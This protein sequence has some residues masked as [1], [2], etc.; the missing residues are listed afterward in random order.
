M[1]LDI[2]AVPYR[3]RIPLSSNTESRHIHVGKYGA[4]EVYVFDPYGMALGKLDRG[5]VSDLEDS[6]FMVK[7]NLL[8]LSEF[9]KLVQEAIPRALEFDMNPKQMQKHLA[10]VRQMLER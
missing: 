9:E 4:V 7:H 2:E 10:A 6:V 5:F 1:D 3:E 8:N